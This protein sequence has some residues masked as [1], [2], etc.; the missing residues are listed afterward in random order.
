MGFGGGPAP[1]LSGIT[2]HQTWGGPLVRV[3]HFGAARPDTGPAVS[4]RDQV[5]DHRRPSD[6]HPLLAHRAGQAPPPRSQGG[7]RPSRHSGHPPSRPDRPARYALWRK[8]PPSMRAVPKPGISFSRVTR[9]CWK[10]VGAPHAHVFDQN[11]AAAIVRL[12][13][14]G[15]TR[16]LTPTDW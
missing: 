16:L 1:V 9:I 2:P 3:P 6:A 7:I 15:K 4:R 8:V 12:P 13:P 10:R 11:R 14:P 5:R